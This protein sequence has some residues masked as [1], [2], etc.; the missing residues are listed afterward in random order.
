MQNCQ[1]T[2]LSIIIINYNTPQLTYNCIVSIKEKTEDVQYEIIVVDNNSNDDSVAFL[3]Q[4]FPDIII[5]ESSEN[6]G[7]GRA[8]NLA[9]E[10]AHADTFFLLNSD[11]IIIDNSI[12]ILYDYLQSHPET[13]VCGG[14]L[15]NAD[16]SIGYSSS[17]KLT[18]THY[19]RSYLPSCFHKTPIE[20]NILN[21][22]DVGYVIG[23]DMMVRKEVLEK[24]GKFDPDFFLYC[25]EAELSHR[26]KKQNYHIQLVPSA[27]II[28]LGGMS[29]T[30]NK[31][32]NEFIVQEQWY[33]R[34][35]Y[36]DKVY[37]SRHPYYLYFLHYF[38]GVLKITCMPSKRIIWRN[39]LKC[40]QK[41]FRK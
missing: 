40:I 41:A 2:E 39:K 38:I 33:S 14:L 4:H 8:N 3:K 37:S 20:N 15:L 10:M 7:F 28:H 34:F 12:K 9:I 1:S 18:L 21:V 25:E 16:G 27:R 22:T 29:G 17:P 23:A 26:I 36:F 24:A 13:G 6:I 30:A 19:F 11:T 31:E 32:L 5:L 35:L